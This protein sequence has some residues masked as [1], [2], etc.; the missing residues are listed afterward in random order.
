MTVTARTTREERVNC[1]GYEYPNLLNRDF[2][3]IL[4]NLKWVMDLSEIKVEGAK[5]FIS[6]IID[7]F[8]RDLIAL[9]VGSRPTY[10]LVEA[11]LNMALKE[12]DLQSMKGILLHTDQGSVF[13]SHQHHIQSQKLGFIS[14][15]SRKA[16]CWD[17]AVMESIFSHYKTEF[18]V[19][20]PLNNYAQ[21]KIDLLTFRIYFNEERSQKRLGYKTSKTF[22]EAHLK[23]LI[24]E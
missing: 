6:A 13:R 23:S 14:S 9:V 19:H 3:A 22:L 7:L 24:Q 15:M 17:N 18:E 4:P 10:E 20:F 8:N 16:N 11:T 1:A 5:L 21:A 12:R 2:N